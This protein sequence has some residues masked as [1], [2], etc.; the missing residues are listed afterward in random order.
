MDPC[1]TDRC[2]LGATGGLDASPLG[3]GVFGIGM[4]DE[5]T[6]IAVGLPYWQN[7]H[8]TCNYNCMASHLHGGNLGHDQGRVL[9]YKRASLSDEW[10]ATPF[11][12]LGAASGGGEQTPDLWP[13]GGAS[14]LQQ[15]YPG[16]ISD[17]AHDYVEHLGWDVVMS[18][19]GAVLAAS[20][21]GNEH[22]NTGG[23][24]VFDWDEAQQKYV[25]RSFGTTNHR[26]R[27]HMSCTNCQTPWRG[28]MF[29]FKL[30][31]DRDGETLAIGWPG[32]RNDGQNR[33][34]VGAARVV[35]LTK[36]GSGWRWDD[37]TSGGSPAFVDLNG[38]GWEQSSST[39]A[40]VSYPR[41]G[42]SV[43][44][45]GDGLRL[46]VGGYG[47]DST[48]IDYLSGGYVR[49]WERADKD[50]AW[51]AMGNV[52]TAGFGSSYDNIAGLSDSQKRHHSDLYWT[53][54]YSTTTA[55]HRTDN[56]GEAVSLSYDGSIIAVGAPWFQDRRQWGYVVWRR[57]DAAA[58]EWKWVGKAPWS[59][60]TG[61][62][63]FKGPDQSQSNGWGE[64]RGSNLGY[65]VHLSD[66]GTVMA[67]SA[68][69]LRNTW[70]GE[71]DAYT[72][73][74]RVFEI[75]DVTSTTELWTMIAPQSSSWGDMAG[76]NSE[77]KFGLGLALSADGRTI[78]MGSG[79]RYKADP[80]KGYLRVRSIASTL[81]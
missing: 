35:D 41:N 74:V 37:W 24:Y 63:Y 12:Q 55:S 21:I 18:G 13:D 57:W 25:R 77:D 45:S 38:Y 7:N 65:S 79:V 4:N 43:A 80:S 56:F 23:V 20:T 11:Q 33:N 62:S 14:N 32:K 42:R 31:L 19:N 27:L 30:S 48:S 81:G 46:A 28:G 44:L 36:T 75:L 58:Q 5:G 22:T 52:D 59:Y 76:S 15:K 49:M 8:A 68:S 53:E 69:G 73:Y 2:T 67:A 66:D 16:W 39:S 29:G 51:H 6:R 64:S 72:G 10:S 78:A 47:H 40:W 34:Q 17:S 61:T 1:Y 9:L 50:S 71:S 60:L 3:S 70:S 26:Y 54:V